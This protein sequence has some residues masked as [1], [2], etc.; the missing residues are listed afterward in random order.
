[1]IKIRMEEQKTFK[2]L[3]YSRKEGI[4]NRYDSVGKRFEKYFRHSERTDQGE[5][6]KII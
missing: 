6:R 3:M 4:S 5:I 2:R 1:M